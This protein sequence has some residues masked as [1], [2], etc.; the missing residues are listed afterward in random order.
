MLVFPAE[1]PI[2]EFLDNCTN[3]GFPAGTQ[4][5]PEVRTVPEFPAGITIPEFP[6]VCMKPESKEV[7]I[8]CRPE[9]LALCEF[10]KLL[11]CASV[12]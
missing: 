9:I 6:E 8:A 4:Q 5:V 1:I 11:V 3:P 2:P 10:P 7:C 12:S